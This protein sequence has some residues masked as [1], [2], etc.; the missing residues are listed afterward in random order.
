MPGDE[1]PQ[2]PPMQLYDMESDVGERINLYSR[3]PEIVEDLT[4]LL[5]S[6]VQTGRSTPGT[7]QENTGPASWPQLAWLERR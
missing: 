3:H 5:A 4:T 1:L 2:M 6:Y 7:P